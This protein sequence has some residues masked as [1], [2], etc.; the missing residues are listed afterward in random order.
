MK[1]IRK[2]LIA[3]VV[4][5]VAAGGVWAYGVR[6]QT[7][8]IARAPNFERTGP[9]Y[10]LVD[11]LRGDVW[12]TRE[13]TPHAYDAFSLPHSWLFWFKND[14]RVGVADGA[15]F[16]RSPG[17]PGDSQYS[18]MKAFGKTFVLVAKLRSTNAGSGNGGLIRGAQVEKY[19]VLRY[20]A[21]R[22]IR[23]LENPAGQSFIA[24]SKSFSRR[25]EPPQLPDGWSFR[26]LAL[27][28]DLTVDLTNVVTVLRLKNEVS[29][30]GPL[31]QA[32]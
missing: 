25:L 19:H 14:A 2:I 28:E 30:Q 22:T 23:K 1:Q 7:G 20:A 4:F 6:G 32:Q 15:K 8:C 3:V 17:C 13:W 10:E 18:Y 27:D 24:V 11:M 9:G 16:L 21:G 29:Y 31:P 12:A 26:E 5:A